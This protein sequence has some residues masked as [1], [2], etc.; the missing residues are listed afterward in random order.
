M[1]TTFWTMLM[2]IISAS[3]LYLRL[4]ASLVLE[5]KRLSS[6]THRTSLAMALTNLVELENRSSSEFSVVVLC[7][8]T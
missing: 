1:K 8:I 6:L 2:I 4:V 7:T 3:F 5:T